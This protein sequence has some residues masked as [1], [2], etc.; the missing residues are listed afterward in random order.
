MYPSRLLLSGYSCV[1][2]KHRT[3]HVF[4]PVLP[5]NTQRLTQKL[6]EPGAGGSFYR[7]VLSSD[8]RASLLVWQGGG[9]P[10]MIL[11]LNLFDRVSFN[12]EVD[13]GGNTHRRR[14]KGA[15]PPR[16]A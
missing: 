5:E 14:D 6:H 1:T 4:A 8:C 15:E 11:R 10:G 2:P 3:L 7:Y 16:H 9:S 13:L 12:F